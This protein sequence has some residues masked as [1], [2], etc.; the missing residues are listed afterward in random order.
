MNYII[1]LLGKFL[2]FLYQ[3]TGDYGLAIIAVTVIIKTCLLP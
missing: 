2:D 1:D 3:M